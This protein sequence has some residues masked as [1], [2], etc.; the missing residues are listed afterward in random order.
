[1]RSH[2]TTAKNRE[3]VF[4]KRRKSTRE[5][6]RYFGICHRFSRLSKF[7][8]PDNRRLDEIERCRVSS[9]LVRRAA[10]LARSIAVPQVFVFAS[11]ARA[12]ATFQPILRDKSAACYTTHPGYTRSMS[13]TTGFNLAT[14]F[15]A[16]L[17][18]RMRTDSVSHSAV[19]ARYYACNSRSNAERSREVHGATWTKI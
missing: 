3:S 13:V 2:A 4:A 10:K 9:D 14:R 18:G 17:P 6:T 7:T 8:A 16:S 19:G 11:R 1:M 15:H 12:R 5:A